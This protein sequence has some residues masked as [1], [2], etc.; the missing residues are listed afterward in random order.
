MRAEQVATTR[1]GGTYVLVSRWICTA[2]SCPPVV[3]RLLV[4]RDD[5]HLST[6]Y[7]AWLAQPR[8]TG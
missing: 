1:A 5:N 6:G 3:G 8:P 7:P 4:Y 2:T